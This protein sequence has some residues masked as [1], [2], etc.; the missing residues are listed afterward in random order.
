M[1]SGGH[2]ITVSS[3]PSARAKSGGLF[4]LVDL[5]ACPSELLT[6]PIGADGHVRAGSVDRNRHRDPE[7]ELQRLYRERV[8]V[9]FLGPQRAACLDTKPH[10]AGFSARFRVTSQMRADRGV[11]GGAP[12]S[13]QLQPWPSETVACDVSSRRF[14]SSTKP[15]VVDPPKGLEYVVGAMQGGPSL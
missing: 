5:E 7:E 6:R 10:V 14:R 9:A 1:P 2:V 8:S 11:G 15:C 4:Q 3:L 12:Q 13:R